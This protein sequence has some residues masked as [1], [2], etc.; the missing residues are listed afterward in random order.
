M[1][2]NLLQVTT[3]SIMPVATLTVSVALCHVAYTTQLSL[4]VLGVLS[5]VPVSSVPSGS[6]VTVTCKPR[7]GN[8]WQGFNFTLTAAS[9][10][11]KQDVTVIT[12]QVAI[13][14][15]AVPVQV[16]SLGATAPLCATDNTTTVRFNVTLDRPTNFTI[17]A[18]S[19][20]AQCVAK[21]L[22]TSLSELSA[23]TLLLVQAHPGCQPRKATS[24]C[25]NLKHCHS[26]DWPPAALF[27]THLVFF[28]FLAT[29][30]L[31]IL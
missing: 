8:G 10:L 29:P 14:H 16:Q 31:I 7:P 26:S 12:T 20:G 6:N 1:R 27:R 28:F 23:D 3:C 2:T 11:C 21:G 9:E 19:S 5:A 17:S 30:P 18:P 24:S 25:H 22:P 13:T 4:C 15:P